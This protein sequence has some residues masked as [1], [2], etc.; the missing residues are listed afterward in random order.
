MIL[1]STSSSSSSCVFWGTT[2]A[3][4]QLPSRLYLSDRPATA[5]QIGLI[6]ILGTAQQR[7]S[8][9]KNMQRCIEGTPWKPPARVLPSMEET[10]RGRRHNSF[11]APPPAVRQP[12]V[13]VQRYWPQSFVLSIIMSKDHKES[14][15]TTTGTLP[16]TTV[17]KTIAIAA[18]HRLRSA[19]SYIV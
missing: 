14:V 16:T 8:R 6:N 13:V 11:G 1:P 15:A 4:H 19:R 7:D 10:R 18:Q 3:P 12:F 2:E 5:M 17:R 9:Q